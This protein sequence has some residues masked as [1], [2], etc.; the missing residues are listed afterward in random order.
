MTFKHQIFTK[1]NQLITEKI[2]L[3]EKN[4]Q[5]LIESS[6]NE[7]KSSAGDKYET[8][9]A[10]L[11]Q[12]QDKVRQQLHDARNQKAFFETLQTLASTTNVCNGSILKTNKNYFFIIL[13]L[14][15][16][17]IDNKTVIALSSNSPLGSK[18]MGKGVG[19]TINLNDT[20]YIIEELL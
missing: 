13:A 3:H 5:E 14:V 10:M 20:Q 1:Y 15:K 6:R 16:I 19:D 7:T 9:R 2:L 8:T 18:L 4:L 11:Q 17:M 12:E